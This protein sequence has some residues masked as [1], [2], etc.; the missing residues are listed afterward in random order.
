MRMLTFIDYIN[1]L[2]TYPRIILGTV[3]FALI[4]VVYLV[5]GILIVRLV[6]WI[7]GLGNDEDRIFE[8]DDFM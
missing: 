3:T 7:G 1:S 5:F 6:D 2:P 4:F 8:D